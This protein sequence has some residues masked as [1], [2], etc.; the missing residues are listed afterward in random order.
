M[1]S[2]HETFKK[3]NTSINEKCIN[4]FTLEDVVR[5]CYP[6]IL[7]RVGKYLKRN[8]PES[9]E[10]A[11]QESILKVIELYKSRKGEWQ[12][13]AHFIGNVRVAII[14]PTLQH[15]FHFVP[16][17]PRIISRAYMLRRGGYET[18]KLSED[19]LGK[20]SKMLLPSD[21]PKDNFIDKIRDHQDIEDILEKNARMRVLVSHLENDF[22]FD[23]HRWGGIK[24][25][26]KEVAKDLLTCL[27]HGTPVRPLSK[28]YGITTQGLSLQAHKLFYVLWYR[29]TYKVGKRSTKITVD[30]MESLYRKNHPESPFTFK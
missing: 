9:K 20:L 6:M 22:K 17:S 29:H 30:Q 19:T 3:R 28:K 15:K 26:H 8:S 23:S 4:E 21:T 5:E 1:K 14:E 16:F 25:N 7:N 10:D 11:V 18:R 24:C 13:L 27:L 12:N 2:L